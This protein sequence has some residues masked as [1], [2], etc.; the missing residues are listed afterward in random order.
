MAF[1]LRQVRCVLLSAPYSTPG[2]AERELHL[3]SGYRSA[4]FFLAESADGITGIGEAYAGSYA[5]EAVRAIAEQIAPSLQDLRVEDI[6]SLMASLRHQVRYWGRSGL[7]QGVLGGIEMALLD[8]QGKLSGKPLFEMLGGRVHASLPFYASGGN[9]KPYADLQAEM[10]GYV[11]QGFGAVKIRI[12]N[13][14]IAKAIEKVGVCAEALEGKASLAV[15]AVQSNTRFPWSL[16]EA[17]QAAE[18]LGRFDLLWL[19][20]PLPPEEVHALGHLRS[21][22]PVPIASG[23][24]ATTL[25]EVERF[26]E[27]GAIDILQ[28]DAAV[29]GVSRFMQAAKL[30]A[31]AGVEIAVHAWC[32]GPGHLANYH[33]A[34]ATPNCTI[35][36]MSAVPNPLREDL[37]TGVCSM[38]KGATSLAELPGLGLNLPDDLEQRYPYRPGSHYT[39]HGAQR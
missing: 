3:R 6:S 30:C 32:G 11:A 1:M 26:L 15:D 27:H 14:P 29:M 38:A 31:G 25:D 33:A 24:T 36:E 5:P 37:I 10:Q 7:T 35:V 19:E 22:S 8:L 39:F 18:A 28:P 20:E 23:E 4:A 12:N 13:L 2:D 9:D 17:M 16:Q 21:V 34:F